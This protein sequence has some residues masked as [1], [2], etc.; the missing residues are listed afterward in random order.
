MC[1]ANRFIAAPEWRPVHPFPPLPDA[2]DAPDVFDG[3]LWIREYLEG[4]PLRF[5]LESD[6][7]L[8]FGNADRTFRQWDEPHPYRHAV[9]HVRQAFSA[10]TLRAAVD[11]PAAHTFFGV[12]T[13]RGRLPYDYGRLPPFVGTEIHERV[14]G[15]L[16]PDRTERAFDRLGLE[17]V[18]VAEKEVSTRHFDPARYEIPES[19]YYVGPAAGVVFRNKTGG[20]ARKLH[21]ALIDDDPEPPD[22]SAEELAQRAVTDERI[23]RALESSRADSVAAVAERVAEM[24]I[25][26]SLGRTVEAIDVDTFQVAVERIVRDRFR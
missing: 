16:A 4:L 3:H 22:A 2:G 19:A 7:V 13:V 11:D 23:D 5:K 15:F 10:D 17:P 25:H 12:A 18:A 1:H 14:E 8:A 20:R 6:G 26:E 9:H 21:P 24:A